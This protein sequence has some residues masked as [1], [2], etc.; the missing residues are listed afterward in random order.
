MKKMMMIAVCGIAAGLFAQGT[1]AVSAKDV[2][3][4]PAVDQMLLD[5]DG[6]C[7]VTAPDGSFQIFTRGTGVYQFATPRRNLPPARWLG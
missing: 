5:D 4:Q 1:A 2:A 3:G 7:I 6:V